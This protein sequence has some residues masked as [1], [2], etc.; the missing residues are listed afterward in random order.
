MI[1]PGADDSLPAVLECEVAIALTAVRTFIA[2]LRKYFVG[3]VFTQNAFTEV[4]FKTGTRM[5]ASP[6]AHH[7][8]HGRRF[9]PIATVFKPSAA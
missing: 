4:R 8:G 3:R 1:G 7:S 2:G 5:Q 9:S 6:F